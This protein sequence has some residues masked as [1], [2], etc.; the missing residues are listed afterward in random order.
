MISDLIGI[1]SKFIPDKSTAAVLEAEIQKA[2]SDAL[3]QA[4]EADKEI[5]LA[6]L[7]AGG[8]AALWRPIAALMIFLCLFLYW[9]IY[10]LLLI[11]VGWFNM[12]VYLPQLPD[13]PTDFYTLSMA[14]ISIYAYGRSLEKRG[15]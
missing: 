2:H 7:H 6:E 11:C 10:P 15:K 12:D 5:K 4:V 14:F 9:F 1:V 3:K 13:L 8:I